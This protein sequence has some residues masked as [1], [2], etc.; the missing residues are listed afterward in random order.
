[1]DD[2]NRAVLMLATVVPQLVELFLAGNDLPTLRGVERLPNLA[3]IDARR[4]KL[5]RPRDAAA[6]LHLPALRQLLL[7]D[8]PLAAAAAPGGSYRDQ[9]WARYAPSAPSLTIDGTA[10]DAKAQ[11]RIAALQTAIAR[12]SP[13]DD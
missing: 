6:V 10:P 3:V 1:M 12:G 7:A 8:C 13:A 5:A 2:D 4:N 11:Q 9:I